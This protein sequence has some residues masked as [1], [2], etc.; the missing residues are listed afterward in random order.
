MRKERKAS[1]QGGAACFLP[2]FFFLPFFLL[3]FFGLTGPAFSAEADTSLWTWDVMVVPPDEGWQSE[4]GSSVQ[5]TLQ[6]HEID[7]AEKGNGIRGHDLRFVWLPPLSEETA[8]DFVLPRAPHPV[9]VMSFA[10]E[11][12]NRILAGRSARLNGLPLLLGGGETVY[13][14][15]GEGRVNPSVFALDLSQDYRCRAFADYAART[16][17]GRARVGVLGA[18]FTFNE[19]REAKI[20][21]DLLADAGFMPMPYW[22]DPSV[23]DSFGMVEQ[24]IKDYSDGVLISYIGNMGSKEIWRGLMGH[25]SAYRIWHGGQ[26]DRSFLSFR[27]MLF[28][29]QNFY[30][31]TRGGFETLKRDLWTSRALAVADKAAAGRANALAFWLR[32]SL[33]ALSGPLER[34][35]LP[36]LLSLLADARDIPFGVQTL[37]IDRA[38]HRPEKRQV[39]LL[40]VRDRSFFVLD[41]FDVRGLGYY[42]R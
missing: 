10:S 20:C 24:E 11:P 17:E 1:A 33:E 36:S 19:E 5:R 2:L 39:F 38:T 34:V 25:R 3:A 26:P 32:Q 21:F 42:D 31:D 29:D 7:V 4:R 6:W 37:S 8:P 22:T 18:R 35:D 41:A 16:L 40:Q 28:A 14:Y 13:L 9:A 30:L 23:S 15:G 12:V 27:G